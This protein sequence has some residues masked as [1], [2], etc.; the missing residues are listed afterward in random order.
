M[1]VPGNR[2]SRQRLSDPLRSPM[3]SIHIWTLSGIP[4]R[5]RLSS[6]RRN[7]N[8]MGDATFRQSAASATLP[9]AARQLADFFSRQTYKRLGSSIATSC[10]CFVR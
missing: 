5:V 8:L 4:Y 9:V 7:G 1:T 3:F 2:N 6:S 10:Q